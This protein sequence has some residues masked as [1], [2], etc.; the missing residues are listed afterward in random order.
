MVSER[1]D[2]SFHFPIPPKHAAA[3]NSLK[4]GGF[5]GLMLYFLSRLVSV[6][7][8]PGIVVGSFCVLFNWNEW[9]KFTHGYL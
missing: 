2:L 1:K 7:F 6:K 8:V 3:L 9:N 4:K 5:E